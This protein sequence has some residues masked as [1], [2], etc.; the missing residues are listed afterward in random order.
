MIRSIRRKV[1]LD[2]SIIVTCARQL[3]AYVVYDAVAAEKI[4]LVQFKILLYSGA[5]EGIVCCGIA[6]AREA[7][8]G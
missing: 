8:A 6:R 2:S 4:R 7:D 5:E 3:I 1:R